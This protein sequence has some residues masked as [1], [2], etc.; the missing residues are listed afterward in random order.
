MA[1]K[2]CHV[3][4]STTLLGLT[5]VLGLMSEF[6]EILLTYLFF[7][8]PWPTAFVNWA[9]TMSAWQPLLL[10]VALGVPVAYLLYRYQKRL[11]LLAWLVVWFMPSTIICGSATAFPWA[12]ALYSLFQEGGCASVLSL[13][14]SFVGNTLIVLAVAAIVRRLKRRPNE[15]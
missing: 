12:F 9:L 2:A 3:F 10:W 5:L 11:A 13:G 6:T 7:V 4:R 1:G 15:A 14:L 8:L